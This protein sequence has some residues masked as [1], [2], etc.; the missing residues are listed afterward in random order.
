MPSIEKSILNP[1]EPLSVV[2]ALK[3][4][5]CGILVVFLVLAVLALLIVVISKVVAKI[6]GKGPVATSAVKPAEVAPAAPKA[7]EDD[8]ELVAVITAA[9]AAAM[10]TTPDTTRL[11]SII[12]Y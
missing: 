9:V 5:V 6:E 4:A 11:T 10:G 8:E 12:R 1:F 3:V 2:D 7:E